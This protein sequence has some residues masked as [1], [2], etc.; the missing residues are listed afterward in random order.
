MNRFIEHLQDTIETAQ[1][2]RHAA[3]RSEFPPSNLLELEMRPYFVPALVETEF[4]A[5]LMLGL[6][7]AGQL[8]A[9]AL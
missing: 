2:K 1:A 8:P 5:G 7:E 9:A 6:V 4:Y 3:E